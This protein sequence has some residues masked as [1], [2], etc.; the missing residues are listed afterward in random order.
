MKSS[1]QNS[2]P[3]KSLI[4]IEIVYK[5]KSSVLRF[6]RTLVLLKEDFFQLI[7]CSYLHYTMLCST[8]KC[9]IFDF[10]SC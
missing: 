2:I 3:T 8:C 1:L 9:L 10:C 5:I 6:H 7:L 4:T